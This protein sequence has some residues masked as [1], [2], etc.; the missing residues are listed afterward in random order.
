MRDIIM[1]HTDDLLKGIKQIAT[2]G[3]GLD[4]QLPDQHIGETI[5]KGMQLITSVLGKFSIAK[6]M[7]E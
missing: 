7:N 6:Y 4:A 2:A 5:E 3:Q 1:K